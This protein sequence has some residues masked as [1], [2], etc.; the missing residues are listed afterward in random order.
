MDPV[1]PDPDSQ[2]WFKEL[3]FSQHILGP[4]PDFVAQNAVILQ[5]TVDF[6]KNFN[7]FT[8]A[9]FLL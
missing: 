6:S 4:F 1:D 2:H 3:A 9:F 5:K 8:L 7:H